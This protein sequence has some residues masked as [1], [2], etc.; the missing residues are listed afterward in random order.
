[1][2]SVRIIDLVLGEFSRAPKMGGCGR[3]LGYSGAGLLVVSMAELAVLF[4]VPVGI[5][6]FKV[7]LLIRGFSASLTIKTS[8]RSGRSEAAEGLPEI[9]SF[10]PGER[11]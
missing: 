10:F 6:G 7:D 8:C 2:T 3:F 11:R 5:G 9:L 1:M 4:D